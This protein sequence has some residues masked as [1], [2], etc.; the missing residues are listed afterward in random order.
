MA[1]EEWNTGEQI[2]SHKLAASIINGHDADGK[3]FVFDDYNLDLLRRFVA[4]PEFSREEILKE[5]D[6]V[7]DVEGEKTARRDGSLGDI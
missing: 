5:N 6:W 3:N 4:D 2:R 1:S 7:D